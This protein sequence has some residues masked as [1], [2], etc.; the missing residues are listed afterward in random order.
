MFC[1]QEKVVYPGY[2]VAKIQRIITKLVSG[3]EATFYEL[4]FLN[5]DMTVLV[6][7]ANAES[8]GLRALSSPELIQDVFDS[9][10]APAQRINHIEF[11]ASNWNKRNKEYQHKLK[12]GDLRELSEIYRDLHFISTYKELSFGEKHLLQQIESLLVE[13]ISLVED[14]G[15]EKTIEHLRSLC[16]T[17]AQKG[18]IIE[19]S[20]Y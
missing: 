15:Q 12:T 14:L 6:P 20:L 3:S 13:E 8:V 4:I 5:K 9:L 18:P 7:T 11:T 16:S 1:L 10:T 19:N 2:G 17:H